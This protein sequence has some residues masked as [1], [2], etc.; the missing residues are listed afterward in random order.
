MEISCRGP[1]IHIPCPAGCAGKSGRRLFIHANRQVV[2]ISPALA[3]PLFCLSLAVTLGAAGLFADRLDH[4]GPRIGLSE[5]LV[6]LLTALAADGP[7]I[8]SALIALA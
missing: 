6:G 8:A 4:L 5:P 7:E 1:P 2:T 3:L